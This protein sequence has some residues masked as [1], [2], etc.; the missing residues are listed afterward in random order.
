MLP[1]P[2]TTAAGAGGAGTAPLPG[3]SSDVSLTVQQGEIVGIFGFLG[4]GMT[5]VARALFGQLRPDAGAI[6]LDGQPDP[7]QVDRWQ[8][9]GSGSPT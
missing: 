5:E 1:P 8:R 6:A 3:P 7:A 2:A 4:A 9:S